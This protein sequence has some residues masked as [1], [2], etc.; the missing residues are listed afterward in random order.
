MNNVFNRTDGF[1]TMFVGNSVIF[2]C[3][4]INYLYIIYNVRWNN[5]ACIKFIFALFSVNPR[6][7]CWR[8]KRKGSKLNK[9]IHINLRKQHPLTP[10][11]PSAYFS[12]VGNVALGLSACISPVK[13]H[14]LDLSMRVTDHV[15]RDWRSAFYLW[16]R[17]ISHQFMQN[18]SSIPGMFQLENMH[19]T[20][21]LFKRSI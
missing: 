12:L 1:F 10:K 21:I 17:A 11:F 13:K 7:V 5:P 20:G 6:C 8:V 3:S 14:Q 9:L 2:F 15:L 16:R 4:K 19:W 18:C